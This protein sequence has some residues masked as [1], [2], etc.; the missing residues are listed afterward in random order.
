MGKK[1]KLGNR[2][3]SSGEE[4]FYQR[5][6]KRNIEGKNTWRMKEHR[7]NEKKILNR[8]GKKEL[9]LEKNNRKKCAGCFSFCTQAS[10][11]VK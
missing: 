5:K 7:G 11:K 6:G 8:E 2:K 3:E 1:G 9:T 4:H 10:R